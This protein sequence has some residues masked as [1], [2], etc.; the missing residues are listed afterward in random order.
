MKNEIHLI[1]IELDLDAATVIQ[2]S[3][4]SKARLD[5]LYWWEEALLMAIEKSLGED[6]G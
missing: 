6:D 4:S 2:K 5:T 3:L 1:S